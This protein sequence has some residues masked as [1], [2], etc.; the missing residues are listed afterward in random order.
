MISEETVSKAHNFFSKDTEI[1]KFMLIL[2]AQIIDFWHPGANVRQ[3]QTETAGEEM[4][5]RERADPK[6]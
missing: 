2:F 6:I 3:Q 5:N 4:S 1:T